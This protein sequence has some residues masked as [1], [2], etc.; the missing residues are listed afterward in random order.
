L[1]NEQFG[2]SAMPWQAMTAA[3]NGQGSSNVKRRNGIFETPTKKKGK[4]K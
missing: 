3:I 1:C 4:R 2:Q